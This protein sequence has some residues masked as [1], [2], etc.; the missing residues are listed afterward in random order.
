MTSYLPPGALLATFHLLP[1]FYPL[2]HPAKQLPLLHVKMRKLHPNL[3]LF[4]P[5]AVSG[6]LKTPK[7]TAGAKRCCNSHQFTSF[8]VLWGANS[9]FLFFHLE[10]FY[11]LILPPFPSP[12]P[13]FIPLG[14]LRVDTEGLQFVKLKSKFCYSAFHSGAHSCCSFGYSLPAHSLSSCC[15]QHQAPCRSLWV[16]R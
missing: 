10:S 7:E 5:S 1:P 14:L 16:Q 2:S 6:N 9:F 11:L 4:S 15:A 13:T 8:F 12:L 3:N